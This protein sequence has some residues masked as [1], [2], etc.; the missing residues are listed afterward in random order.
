MRPVCQAERAAVHCVPPEQRT[1]AGP[2][3]DVSGGGLTNHKSTGIKHIYV[4][5]FSEMGILYFPVSVI[6]GQI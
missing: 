6:S 3:A 2:G 1:F 4:I 5:P